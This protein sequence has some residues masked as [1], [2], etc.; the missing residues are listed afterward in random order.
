MKREL[1][2]EMAQIAIRSIRGNL[3]R[4]GLTVGVIGLGIMALISM[5]TATSSLEANVVRQFSTLGTDVFTFSQ[6][7]ET[8]VN[9]G[10]RVRVGEPISYEEAQRFAKEAP[11]DLQVAYS[12]FGTSQATLTRG[13]D[14]TNPNIQV[15]GIEENY[16]DVGGYTH[17]IRSR[18][19]SR[20]SSI[21]PPFGH[22]R[23]GPRERTFQSLGRP[24]GTENFQ[25]EL[26]RYQVIGVLAQKGQAFGMS[27]DNQC[28][29]PIPC[30]R[31]QFSDE[32]RSYRIAC[33]A[34]TPE[35]VMELAEAATGV[36]RVVRRDKPGQDLSFNISMSNSLV[37]TL[38]G[39]HQWYHDRCFHYWHNHLIRG[40]YRI[41][42]HH[43]RQR[44]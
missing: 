4:T 28:Y 15:L 16:T 17:R 31:Q 2:I 19:Y 37:S 41:D 14:R 26:Q 40:G 7:T 44:L 11:K 12:I 42:E 29:V 18:V 25:L 5:T 20:R 27:Q 38:G 39:G 9:R 33:K 34:P 10:R 32:N 23:S 22:L 13:T 3:L 35:D 1:L 30:V 21:F 43:A 8:G 24:P 6:R 36:L